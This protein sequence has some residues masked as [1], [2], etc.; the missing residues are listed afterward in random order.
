MNPVKS[1]RG[2]IFVFYLL[3]GMGLVLS[4]C[5]DYTDNEIY[6]P[7]ANLEGKLYEQI[8]L[9]ENSDLS[10]FAQCL[11]L[12]G[13]S[14]I[15]NKTGYYTVF[16]P[17]DEAF[18][19]FFNLHPEYNGDVANIPSGE[20]EKLVRFHIVQNGWTK[21]QLTSM[22]YLGWIDPD[23]QFYNKPKGFKRAT[24]LL[25]TLKKEWVRL[26]KFNTEIVD[27][28][29]ADAYRVVFPDSRKY[30]PLF[31]QAYM[32][33][34][35]Y[36]SSDYEFYFDRPFEG[37]EHI[38]FA[39][40]KL[41][42]DEIAAE[43][44]FIYKI[45]R[46]VSPMDNMKQIL[47]DDD[48]Y[49]SFLGM[50]HRFPE[51]Q[52]DLEE[53]F[54]QAGARE[55]LKVD[56]L[57]SLSF[58]DLTFSINK[59]VTGQVGS[60]VNY[61]LR[62]HNSLIAPTNDAIEELYN[63]IILSSSGYPHYTQKGDVPDAITKIIINSHMTG[64]LLYESDLI[65]GF[66]NGEGDRISIDPSSI[67]SIEYG[68]NG[69]FIGVD[70]AVVPFAFKSVAA[71]VY[72]RPG[73]ETFFYAIENTNIL[74]ALTKADVKYSFY[75]IE[76]LTLAE[77]SSLLLIWDD[78]D[79]G[80]YH[81]DA[82]DR[83]QERFARIRQNDLTKWIMNQIVVEEPA[84][85]ARKEFLENLGGNYIVVNNEDNSV[86][87]ALP[88][89]FGFEGDSS[90]TVIPER[91]EEPSE[92]GTTYEVNSWFLNS[93]SSLYS[94][95]SRNRKFLDL[96]DQTG[97]AEKITFRIMFLSETE[98]YT[99]FVP[100][101]EA[102]ENY[103]VDTMSNEEIERLLRLHFVKGHLIFTDGKKPAGEYETMQVDEERSD[104]FSTYYTK[105]SIEPDLDVIRILD[106]SGGLILE[107]EESDLFTNVT[108]ARDADEDGESRYD[109]VTNSVV[110]F[111][112]HVIDFP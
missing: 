63:N 11:E 103:G 74:P 46:V 2:C 91:L 49:E 89:V 29:A 97:L 38:Y 25:D 80:K 84:G 72:L 23:D 108:A 14:E 5:L 93:V 54:N 88:S 82:Y 7:P 34:F 69:V 78:R 107:V 85:V 87:G 73:Y 64:E 58:P 47:E 16:A 76:D 79:A 42:S 24:I 37:G 9:E 52:V 33:A 4:G 102:L 75:I 95:L 1:C 32:D 48:D 56:T 70:E 71:P 36:T 61:T 96:M 109:F 43:N 67:T 10:T 12:S 104:Q 111:I 39:N 51:F 6:K 28:S 65:S 94:V 20:L 45:D 22:D 77:D 19:L 18:G 62:E 106:D 35:N 27:E 101:D 68:S 92:N 55:G 86:Q 44:G 30:A 66:S 40:G 100:S 17:T 15:I 13:L 50:I 83:A 81:F 99:V 26:D 57:Y 53:T 41:V 3:A 8:Q 112:D 59:E 110:H 31:F 105:L 98:F 90:I 21:G 60:S